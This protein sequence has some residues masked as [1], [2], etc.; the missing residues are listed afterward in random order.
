MDHSF[1]FSSLWN[2]KIFLCIYFLLPI[3]P[4]VGGHHLPFEM[5]TL[6]WFPSITFQLYFNIVFRIIFQAIL[7]ST[8]CTLITC[9]IWFIKMRLFWVYQLHKRSVTKFLNSSLSNFTTAQPR[10]DFAFFKLAFF[11]IVP[12]YFFLL[13]AKVYGLFVSLNYSNTF[14]YFKCEKTQW[15]QRQLCEW[16]WIE[17]KLRN[18]GCSYNAVLAKANC[19]DSVRLHLMV[20]KFSRY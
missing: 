2:R 18:E 1:S 4:W 12:Y 13:E 7:I 15:V 11:K 3:C 8:Y 5:L 6:R 14:R 16:K 9:Q 10:L 20:L 19:L 17:G